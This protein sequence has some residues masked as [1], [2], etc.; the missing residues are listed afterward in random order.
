MNTQTRFWTALLAASALTACSA[1]EDTAGTPEETAPAEAAEATGTNPDTAAEE[2]EEAAGLPRVDIYIAPLSWV[3]DIPSLGPI[4]NATGRAGYDN[5]P[6]FAGDGAHFYF[7]SGDDEHTDIWRCNLDCSV[8][9]QITDTPGSGEY[10]PR[11]TPSGGALSYIYQPPGGYGGEVWYDDPDGGNARP[12]SR[13]GPNGYYAFNA[14]MT[15]LAVFALGDTFRLQVFGR[16][17]DTGP[18]TVAE[19]IGRALYAAPDHESVY[20]TL[21]RED[22][23]YSIHE[24]G[25]DGAGTAR[26]FDLPGTAEDYAVFALAD[27]R[28]AFFAVDEGVLM[29][30]TRSTPWHSIADLEAEGLSGMTR[31]A[32]SADRRHIAIVADD[33]SGG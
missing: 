8:I 12:A 13:H 31:L 3:G 21:P 14:D 6:A 28:D 15:R 11:P 5:Q 20:F 29:M 2:P 18:V 24:T 19:N 1:P 10:S 9:E 33:P 25:F 30:R 32:V 22:E 17:E 23:G 4:H 26:V 16:F 7:T 27:G